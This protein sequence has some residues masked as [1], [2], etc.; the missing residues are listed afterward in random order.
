MV[1]LL[2]IVLQ[3]YAG[4]ALLIDSEDPTEAALN[5]VLL[6]SEGTWGLQV[7]VPPLRRRRAA[8]PGTTSMPASLR[9]RCI[10]EACSPGP[11]CCISLK[12]GSRASSWIVVLK[13]V[14][15]SRLAAAL[16]R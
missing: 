14:I 7:G 13:V 5:E 4:Q 15:E 16:G 10:Q 12:V 3:M 2:Q 6:S 1:A 9:A 8:C 11:Q